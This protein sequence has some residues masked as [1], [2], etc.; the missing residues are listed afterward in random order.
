MTGFCIA[1]LLRRSL[2][3]IGLV[4]VAALIPV[5]LR[6]QSSEDSTVPT[7]APTFLDKT[8]VG[9]YG[10]ITYT[11]PDE[12]RP[13]LD[14]PRFV[15][16]L[17]H[18]FNDKWSFKSELEIEHVKLERGEGGEV[19]LEQAFLDYHASNSIAWRG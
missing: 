18:Y 12:G 5:A 8:H 19:A 2:N 3:P 9:G 10:E 7:N 15:I 13:R 16:Y 17:D 1:S 11:L 14:M 6:A 4:L